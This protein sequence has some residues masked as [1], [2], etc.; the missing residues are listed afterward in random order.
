MFAAV[1][2]L[3]RSGLKLVRA[4][5]VL[6]GG[7]RPART[8]LARCTRSS[9]LSPG[10]GKP[11]TPTGISTLRAEGRQVRKAYDR[12][13]SPGGGVQDPGWLV[14]PGWIREARPTNHSPPASRRCVSRAPLVSPAPPPQRGNGFH[15][16]PYRRPAVGELPRNG[17]V[18]RQPGESRLSGM[19][20]SPPPARAPSS[21]LIVRLLG[22]TRGSGSASVP[23]SAPSVGSVSI[24]KIFP[25]WVRFPGFLLLGDCEAPRVPFLRSV[26][27]VR[28]PLA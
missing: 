25:V 7:A 17:Q 21:P 8:V 22:Q 16:V 1:G 23:V 2:G 19:R 24:G 20:H 4:G 27:V 9:A 5:E 13:C 6:G 3:A 10:E 18:P 11:W 15:R 14:P 26:S 12:P 28:V